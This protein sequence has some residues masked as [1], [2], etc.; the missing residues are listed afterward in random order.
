MKPFFC[1]LWNSWSVKKHPLNPYFSEHSLHLFYSNRNLASPRGG[2]FP[3]STSQLGSCCLGLFSSSV[4]IHLDLEVWTCPSSHS[5]AL[6]SGNHITLLRPTVS[7]G[8]HLTWQGWFLPLE[9]FLHLVFRT[10]HSPDSFPVALAIPSHFPL[11]SSPQISSKVNIGVSC[12]SLLRSLH[13]SILFSHWF[14]P[15]L[16]N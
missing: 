4:L 6:I 10:Q 5:F 7:F 2:C 15:V 8:S 13:S 11:L 12:G 16:W 1:A 9:T 14:C 3:C